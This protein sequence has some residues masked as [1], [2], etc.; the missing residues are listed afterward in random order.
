M[1]VTILVPVYGVEHHI[2]QCAESLFSQTYPD[3]EYLFCDDCTPDRSIAILRDVMERFP[4]RRQHVRIIRNS[5]NRGSGGTRAH[6]M[7]E[8]HTDCFLFADSDDIMP[9]HA[10][11]YLVQRMIA[12]NADVIDGAFMRYT[13]GTLSAPILP[14]HDPLPLYRRKVQAANMLRHQIWGRLYRSSILEKVPQLFFDGIDM[15]EDYCITTRLAAVISRDWTDEVVYHYRVEQQSSF[16]GGLSERN[17]P[18]FLRAVKTVLSFYHQRGHLPL[19]LEIG[20]LDAYRI[21]HREAY[22]TPS[23]V[24]DALRYVP[25]HFRARLLYAMLHSTSLPYSVTNLLYRI[26]RWVAVYL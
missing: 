17:I 16:G 2:A 23:M 5:E 24:D 18:S 21:A 26:I 10:V 13:N 7:E 8:L 9:P 20:I 14:S 6:L 19:P 12:T 22:L 25:E 1:Q 3:I 11:E 15:A 4:E